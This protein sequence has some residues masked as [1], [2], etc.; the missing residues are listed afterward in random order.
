[1]RVGDAP[2]P[3]AP[4]ACS[5]Q[6]PP[7][8]KEQRFSHFTRFITS[9]GGLFLP[10]GPSKIDPYSWRRASTRERAQ[11]RHNP[12]VQGEHPGDRGCPVLMGAICV[13]D[14]LRAWSRGRAI[15]R[16]SDGSATM[17]CSHRVRRT[18]REHSHRG[19]ERAPAS[20]RGYMGSVCRINRS[21]TWSCS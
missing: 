11:R 13:F 12:R 16:W 14:C 8:A 6:S 21:Y 4:G 17:L 2:R 9:G 15:L 5:Q 18:G 3:Q 20:Y 7:T 10:R 19:P 1:M